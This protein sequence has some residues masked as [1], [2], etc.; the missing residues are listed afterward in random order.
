MNTRKHINI[1]RHTYRHIHASM[2]ISPHVH[3]YIQY[4]AIHRHTPMNKWIQQ[5]IDWL[6]KTIFG[7][8]L[9]TSF[10]N[11]LLLFCCSN[12]KMVFPYF[13]NTR[14]CECVVYIIIVDVAGTNHHRH[15]RADILSSQTLKIAISHF[16][17]CPLVIF[18]VHR[19][20][21]WYRWDEIKRATLSHHRRR[22][23]YPLVTDVGSGILSSLWSGG[24]IVR[25]R[26]PKGVTSEKR[27]PQGD[28]IP[29]QI[30]GPTFSRHAFVSSY[31]K[32]TMTSRHIYQREISHLSS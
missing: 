32:R 20:M 8:Q 27:R 1:Y 24:A 12:Y 31:M 23:K 9:D 26:H 16:H 7:Q 21:E 29:S 11:S 14:E 5:E 2:Y 4:Y 18:T 3:I 13:P 22:R 17:R 28:V 19:P 30:S 10:Y 6:I 15:R 25:H